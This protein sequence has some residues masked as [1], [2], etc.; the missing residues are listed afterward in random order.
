MG[1]GAEE[2][3]EGM[4]GWDMVCLH[5]PSKDMMREGETD[6]EETECNLAKCSPGRNPD[7]AVGR[8]DGRTDERRI[9]SDREMDQCDGEE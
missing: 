1:G 2:G 8:A 9:R 4:M 3:T 7:R 6:R 5:R